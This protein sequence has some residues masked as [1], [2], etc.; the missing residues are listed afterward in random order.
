MR[1]V[2][3][4][5]NCLLQ[6]ISR[7]SPYYV[8]WQAFHDGKYYLCVSNEIISEYQEIITRLTNPFVAENIVGTILK[9]TYC[10]QFDPKFRFGLI[11]TDP[12]DNKFVD[13][14]II[15]NADYVVSEDS[16]FK[17]LDFVSFPKVRVLSIRD[18]VEDI[19]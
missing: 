9:S 8:G 14:A 5:T 16:H 19:K 6:M 2:V 10:L 11:S 18:F 1:H 15:A 7:H 12:D 13:C 3:I 17:E 4:D